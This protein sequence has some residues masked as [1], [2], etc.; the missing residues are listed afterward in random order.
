MDFTVPPTT[1]DCL[2]TNFG[3]RALSGGGQVQ[4]KKVW[5]T[6]SA[7]AFSR[8]CSHVDHI[9]C[10]VC[11]FWKKSGFSPV[12]LR[13]TPVSLLQYT[14]VHLGTMGSFALGRPVRCTNVS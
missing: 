8:C 2:R 10:L 4:R 9:G 13:Q 11:R 5:S 1:Y 6:V 14:S 3:G 7:M 12:Y